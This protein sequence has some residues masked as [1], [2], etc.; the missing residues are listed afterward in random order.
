MEQ[1]G[2][3]KSS[4]GLDKN[5]LDN[6]GKV[7]WNLS[8]PALYQEALIRGEAS[9]AAGG[10]LVALTGQHTGRSAN[11]KFIVKESSSENNIWWGQV[12]K[13]IDAEKFTG[14][15]EKMRQYLTGREVFVQDCYAGADPA[16]RL[17]VRVITECAWHN[18]FARNMFIQPAAE[19][20]ANFEPEFT[21][22]QIPSFEA[23]PAVDGTRSEVFVL[24]NFAEKLV[25]IGGTSYAGEIKKSVFSI[26]NYLLPEKQT[27]P[28]HCSVN[29]NEEGNSTV[30]FGLSG[31][32]KTT[33]SADASKML[34][35]DD[36]HGWSDD[37]VFNFEGGCY[38]KVIK[39]S[40]EAEPEI[41]ETTRRFGTVLENVVVDDATGEL[42]L[43]DN[44]YTEN[45][46]ASYPIDFI[47]NA[48]DTGIAGNP[49]NVIMLTADAFGVLPPIS[50]LTPEQAMY[51]FLSGYTA[52]L[53]GTEK[54]LGSE[55]QATFSTCFGAPFMPR[56]P[57]VYASLLGDKIA[58]HGVN[59]WLVNTG[60]T[61]GEYG[62]GHRMPIGYT[63]A[64]VNA[65]LDGT[66]AKT[67]T[68]KDPFFGL[69]MPVSCSGVP[70][71]I[72][73][74]RNTWSDKAAYDAKAQDLVSRFIENFE[75]FSD[76]VGPEVLESAPK[77]A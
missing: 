60:W 6:V 71:E 50:K 34:I 49:T 46:R 48:S 39:L 27:L 7:Y 35:G 73:N 66:L 32:G 22:L 26:L 61:G 37:G 74:P 4:Y 2:P 17:P 1:L 14:L 59:C 36:E 70:T 54:G 42:D 9:L 45:T 64:L 67:D 33:L 51:H 57:S 25:I 18:L 3:H 55:P 44:R 75:Q 58:K 28:M 47:P 62:T 19:E 23:N 5:G 21:I 8:A 43:D 13:P 40:Q 68:E 65:A 69:A 53:A 52:K 76:Y 41:F 30:F 16:H 63:R 20:L 31:T 29:V 72:L 38:A 24:P 77:T 56:H 15:H 11:D 10:P 12:N